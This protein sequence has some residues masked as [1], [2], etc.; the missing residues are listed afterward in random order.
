M[1]VCRPSTTWD[2]HPFNIRN[3]REQV[4]TIKPVVE[5]LLQLRNNTNSLAT[6]DRICR[7]C[8]VRKNHGRVLHS[9]PSLSRQ[10]SWHWC[11]RTTYHS[12][13]LVHSRHCFVTTHIGNGGRHPPIQ[14]E[15]L[16]R[17]SHPPHRRLYPGW[18]A[19]C[20]KHQSILLHT[21]LRRRWDPHL[22]L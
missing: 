2:L 1:K 10:C 7:V 17:C 5:E 11:F 15:W 20:G 21:H 12:G 19:F 9:I 8:I 3:N 22:C 4:A 14:L 13:E 16:S 18:C 6:F